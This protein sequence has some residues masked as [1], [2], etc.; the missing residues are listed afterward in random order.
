MSP[1]LT[2]LVMLVKLSYFSVQDGN[3][4]T[5]EQRIQALNLLEAWPII[6]TAEDGVNLETCNNEEE[7]RASLR[8]REIG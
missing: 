7:L 8:A 3:L 5:F 2:Y 4:L 1:M 6:L